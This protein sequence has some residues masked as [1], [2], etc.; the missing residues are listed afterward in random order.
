[1]MFLVIVLF[2]KAT[3]LTAFVHTHYGILWLEYNIQ[4]NAFSFSF[5]P[6]FYH[7]RVI[8]CCKYVVYLRRYIGIWCPF[9]N[10]FSY[11]LPHIHSSIFVNFISHVWPIFDRK[12]KI[13][14]FIFDFM[15]QNA[16]HT[17]SISGA[18]ERCT[19]YVFCDVYFNGE[20]GFILGCSDFGSLFELFTFATA[21]LT[22]LK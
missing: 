3:Y 18:D 6:F 5:N 13:F 11:N 22:L 19:I 17:V 15:W 8:H 4:L 1:M 14:S 10:S 16:Y 7:C 20:L 12:R 2:Q 21:K 9:R